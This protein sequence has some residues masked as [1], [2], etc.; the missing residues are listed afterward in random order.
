MIV[1][2]NPADPMFYSQLGR[3]DKM[4]VD[5]RMHTSVSCM[6]VGSANLLVAGRDIT[7]SMVNIFKV[8]LCISN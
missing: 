7:P 6:F 5:T 4:L 3:F 2:F 8:S 1:L